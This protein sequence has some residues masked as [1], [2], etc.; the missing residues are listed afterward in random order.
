[1]T[2]RQSKPNERIG[3]LLAFEEPMAGTA[4]TTFTFKPNGEKT[5][6]TWTME[7]TA[8][9]IEKAICAVFF[10]QDKMVGGMFEQG[11]SNLDAVTKTAARQ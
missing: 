8:G 4:D 1:M 9:F 3:I 10:D 7:G 2:I 6:V 5:D 11:L